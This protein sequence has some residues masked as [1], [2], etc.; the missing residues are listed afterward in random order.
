MA[1][2]IL[3]IS[4]MLILA[5]ALA[6]CG[7]SDPASSEE[8]RQTQQ[9]QDQTKAPAEA[10]QLL[11]E[12][13][14]QILEVELEENEAAEALAKLAGEDGLKL[15]L[16]EY[17]GFEKVGQ[18]PQSLPASDQQIDTSP[19]DIVLYQGDQ[20]SLFYGENSWSYTRLGHMKGVS[21]GQLQDLL[22]DGDISVT[23][24]KAE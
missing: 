20:I 7:G 10:D 1:R 16:T 21:A 13:N 3:L 9:T 17:G 15:D 11:L 5:F 22:G 14:D 12:V 8:A 19:G 24:K 4:F 2:R 6:G 23:L 18:L